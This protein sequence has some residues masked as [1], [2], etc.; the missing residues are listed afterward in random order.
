MADIISDPPMDTRE[1]P[2]QEINEPTDVN[3]VEPVEI[4]EPVPAIKQQSID[5]P[6]SR[7]RTELKNPFGTLT[8]VAY[9][10]VIW[11]KP[12]NSGIVLGGSLAFLIFTSLFSAFN[13]ICAAAVFI[14]GANTA[15]VF[16]L[17]QY[18]T[19][20]KQEDAHPYAKYLDNPP[21]LLRTFVDRYYDVGV[22]GI[23]YTAQEGTKIVLVEDTSRSL[24]YVLGCFVLWTLGSWFSFVTLLGI[25]LVLGFTLPIAYQKNKVVVD[26]KYAVAAAAARTY[27]DQGLE[28]AKKYTGDIFAKGKN[29]AKGEAEKKKE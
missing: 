12:V 17:K 28:L 5:L 16:A 1:I 9:R 27:T 29:M 8:P 25:A 11:E 21:Q 10:L 26:A 18:K 2:S 13:A 22:D 14:I 3:P 7:K 4:V 15:Y 24:K 6:Q 20:F 23:N 19:V